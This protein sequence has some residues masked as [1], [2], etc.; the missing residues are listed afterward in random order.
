MSEETERGGLPIRHFASQAE[1]ESWLGAQPADHPGI[2]LKLAK[3]G[4]DVPTVTRREAID[5]GL[6]F[7]WIDGQINGL[8]EQFYVIRY[9]TR[10][11]RSKWSD[12]NARRAEQLLADGRMR[13]G[14]LRQIEAARA[15]GRW[16]AAYPP[17][18]R[19]EVP[20]DLTAALAASPVAAAFFATLTGANRY[21]VLYRLHDVRDPNK[22]VAAVARWVAML[23]RG[24]MVHG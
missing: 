4:A 12:V 13:P 23:K 24:E 1:L 6:C 14:G 11:P 7:G 2:W 10:R 15:D 19:I 22:R 17:A 3:K 20:D 8:D 9:T 21:A 16:D 5:S 18:S